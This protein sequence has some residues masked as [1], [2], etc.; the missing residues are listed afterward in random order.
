MVCDIDFDFFLLFMHASDAVQILDEWNFNEHDRIHAGGG[1]CLH[2]IY[3]SQDHD[4]TPVDCL[5][6]QA[7]MILRNKVI[8]D[9]EH[10]NLS[11]SYLHSV[12][13]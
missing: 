4:K 10:L 3:R 11:L 8:R 7:Q 12:S 6:N 1:H 2:C 5:V 9:G 13:S